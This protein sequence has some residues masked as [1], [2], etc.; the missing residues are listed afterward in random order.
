M[1]IDILLYYF[2]IQS[3]LSTLYRKYKKINKIFLI[4]KKNY[5]ECK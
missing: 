4:T 5:G 2:K 3:D 1:Q